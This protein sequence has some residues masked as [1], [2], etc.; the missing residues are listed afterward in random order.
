M[1]SQLDAAAAPSAD[2]TQ[3]RPGDRGQIAL[4]TFAHGVQHFYS[5]AFAFSYSFAVGAFDV[6]YATL[7]LVLGT[8]GV[9][10]GLLQIVAGMVR[11]VP[12]RWLLVGQDVGLAAMMVLAALAPSFALFALAPCLGALVSWPQHPVGSAYLSERVPLHRTIALSWHTIGGS[13][14][15]L[16][17]PLVAGVVTHWWGW[18]W[19]LLVFVPAVL[20][21]ALLLWLRLDD[22]TRGGHGTDTAD[23][24]DPAHSAHHGRLVVRLPAAD[25]DPSDRPKVSLARAL[26]R[27]SVIAVLAAGTVA[28][29]GRGLGVLTTYV[30]AY[31][32]DGKHLSS[33]TMGLLFAIVM[34]GSVAGPA[35]AGQLADRI[36]R[37]AVLLVVYPVGALC[38]AGYILVGSSVW[39]LAGVGLL[40]GVFAYSESPLLQA[41]FADSVQGADHRA[42]FG[43]FFAI[44]YGIGALWQVLIGWLVT[45]HGFH[46]AFV[47]MA[48]SFV[49]AGALIVAARDGD[50]RPVAAAG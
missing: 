2:P 30:P 45:A 32:H 43:T 13:I 6:S 50:S 34:V 35:L 8:A 10:G 33:V 49:F 5:A 12:A 25:A 40:V 19:G 44:S 41:L 38:L 1:S 24:A 47:V 7:G 28:A 26:R 37:R 15:T 4:L 29:G 36:G 27:R 3:W 18:R 11:Q 17:V 23:A 14:G 39:A 16:V 21:G 46:A 22:P 48:V 20:F 42:A 31:L 9:V